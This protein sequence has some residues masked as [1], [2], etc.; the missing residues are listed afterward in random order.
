MIYI[1]SYQ[2]FCESYNK[3]RVGKKRW[4]M[5]YKRR[6]NCNNPKGF[7]QKQFCKRIKKGGKYKNDA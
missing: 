7:S 6:I 2:S 1:E 4:S 3:P 5:K